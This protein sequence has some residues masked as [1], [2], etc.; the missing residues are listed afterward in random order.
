MDRLFDWFDTRSFFS[1][2][3]NVDDITPIRL[4]C[5]LRDGTGHSIRIVKDKK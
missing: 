2:W 5:V 3:N 4:R 1:D